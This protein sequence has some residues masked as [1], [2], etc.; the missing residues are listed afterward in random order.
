MQRTMSNSYVWRSRSRI[1]S[2]PVGQVW[3]H[4]PE[5][6][7]RLLLGT[8]FVI[9]VLDQ[10]EAELTL[11]EREHRHPHLRLLGLVRN[12]VDEL[13]NGLLLGDLLRD[14][15]HVVAGE[16]AVDRLRREL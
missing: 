2:A 11:F 6:A 4:A 16:I 8:R 13:G 1:I 7:R 3:A 10:L 9:S 5:T 15:G 12:D 14:T